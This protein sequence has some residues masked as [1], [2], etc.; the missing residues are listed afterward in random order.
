MENIEK[1]ATTIGPFTPCRP[2][3]RT[4]VY[5]VPAEKPPK[6]PIRAGNETIPEEGFATNAAPIKARR[7]LSHSILFGI[8]PRIKI[9][10]RIAKKR[11]EFIEHI[12][13]GDPQMIH[14]PEIRQD[15]GRSEGASQDQGKQTLL[16]DSDPLP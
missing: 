13:I 7:T 6:I 2:S 3:L 8:S 16:L 11:R 9:D 14:G 5:A 1:N 4:K 12:G 15:P 10:M